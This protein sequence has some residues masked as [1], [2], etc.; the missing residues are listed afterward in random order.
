MFSRTHALSRVRVAALALSLGLC[1]PAAQAGFITAQAAQNP[2]DLVSNSSLTA[3]RV[4][5]TVRQAS[6]Y[7]TRTEVDSKADGAGTEAQTA[8]Q[9]GAG[10]S[11]TYALWDVNRNQALTPAEAQQL[12]LS[13]NFTL[14][15]SFQVGATDKA[16]AG[17]SYLLGMDLVNGGSQTI[18]GSLAGAYAE[19]E[20]IGGFGFVGD[21][22]LLGGYSLN[23]S[24]RH[25]NAATGGL[26]MIVTNTAAVDA[27]ANSTLTLMS[28]GLVGGAPSGR[29]N[30]AASQDFFFSAGALAIRI[31]ETGL[32]IPV[33]VAATAVPEPGGVAFAALG[34]LLL[35]GWQRKVQRRLGAVR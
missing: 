27:M 5:A 12:E 22:R 32:L 3:D 17:T 19:D 7:A 11:A 34:L 21:L 35:T 6:A 30:N 13:F 28:V 18:S 2:F 8:F 29:L 26:N 10:N 31:N 9:S 33:G 25:V 16:A 14:T 23:F 4:S 1:W 20:E 24:L 15:G